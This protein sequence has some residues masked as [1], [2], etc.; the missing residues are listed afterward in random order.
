MDNLTKPRKL[1][2]VSGK[3]SDP[4]GNYFQSK[5]VETA[6]RVSAQLWSL[7]I[8]NLCPHTLTGFMEGASGYEEIM[9]G[10]LLMIE[11]SDFVLMLPNYSESAGAVRERIFAIEHEKPVFYWPSSVGAMIDFCWPRGIPP[12]YEKYIEQTV[13]SATLEIADSYAYQ[14]AST[15]CHERLAP[16]TIHLGKVSGPVSGFLPESQT[17]C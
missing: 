8:P 9:L 1:A 13:D 11:R 14:E 2:F 7:G 12:E 5:N 10:C 15:R 6:R 16:Q 17:N 4:R 3:Y